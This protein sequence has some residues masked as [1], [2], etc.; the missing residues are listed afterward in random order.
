MERQEET[1]RRVERAEDFDALFEL[2]KEV[3]ER[4]IREHRAGLSLLLTDM[5]PYVGAYHPFGSNAIV[6]NRSLVN[7]LRKEVTDPRELNSFIFTLLMH[8]YLHSMGHLDDAEVRRMVSNICG[9]ALG[10]SHMTVKMSS[11]DWLGRYP[12]LSSLKDAFSD[13]FESVTK[14]DS[15][16]KS[17]MG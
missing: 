12:G 6:V 15:S 13:S 5:P 4:E 8:E 1:R 2:V 3:V 11:A 14:F 10:E 9:R 17:Y 7:A 16:S